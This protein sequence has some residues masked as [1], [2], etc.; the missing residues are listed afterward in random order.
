MKIKYIKLIAL[1]FGLA[2]TTFITSCKPE[3][4]QPDISLFLPANFPQPVY[5][6][7]TNPITPEGFALG[8]KLFFD[9]ILSRDSSVS[10]GFCHIPT[11]AFS[12]AAHPVSHGIEDKLGIRNAPAVMNMVWHTTFFWDGGVHNLDFTGL[13]A[14][15]NPVE[16]DE[17]LP[18]LMVKLKRQQTYRKMFTDAFGSDEINTQTLTKALSQFMAM[19]VSANSRYDKYVRNEAGGNLTPDELEG[20]QLFKEK[21]CNTCHATDLF[22]DFSFRNNGIKDSFDDDKGRFLVTLNPN[23]TG[24]FKVPSL[25]NLQYTYPYMHNGSIGTLEAV[26]QHYA[27]GVLPSQT[28][29]SLLIQPDGTPGIPMTELEQTKIIAFLKTLTDPQFIKDPRFAE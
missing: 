5:N 17:Q 1:L 23:D 6:T 21:K 24:K 11:A 7:D 26:L 27:G 22:S 29:D 16:M 20:L 2:F 28:L 13:N 25:R 10:C 19:L 14:I 8:K 4:N 15:Q 3:D 9:P 12:N 18:N